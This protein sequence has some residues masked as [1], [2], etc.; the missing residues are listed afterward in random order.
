MAVLGIIAA[1]GVFAGLNPSYT[2]FELAH[3]IR[4]ADITHLLVEP[5]FLPKAVRAAEECSIPE[6]NIFAFDTHGHTIPADFRVRSWNV[7]QVQGG[8]M[9][10]EAFHDRRR[11]EETSV[12]RLFSNGTTGL[13]KALN[14]S[15]W[16]LAGI[17]V[18]FLST[19]VYTD[20]A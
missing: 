13:S 4:T 18:S 15:T 6:S 5:G 10:W 16:N 20:T 11:S 19:T 2:T 1:G 17:L 8:E 9:D 7:L 3:A 12:A 14:V